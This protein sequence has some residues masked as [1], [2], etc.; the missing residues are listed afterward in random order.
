MRAYCRCLKKRHARKGIALVGAPIRTA[1]DFDRAF[2]TDVER[3]SQFGASTIIPDHDTSAGS[4][5]ADLGI[6]HRLPTMFA[7][8]ANV[9]AGGLHELWPEL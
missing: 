4:A 3:K 2:D 9:E 7:N 5:L 8:R 1:D 6:K